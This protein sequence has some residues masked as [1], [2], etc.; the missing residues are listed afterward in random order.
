MPCIQTIPHLSEIYS[1][2][3]NEEIVVLGI[4]SKDNNANSIKK[5]PEFIKKNKMLYRT[6]LVNPEVDKKYKVNVY[7]SMYVIDKEGKILVSQIGYNDNL[8][9]GLSNYLDK[10]LK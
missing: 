9:E 10:I 7:P 5:L 6:I 3:K 4:N 1:K 8:K 2:Y